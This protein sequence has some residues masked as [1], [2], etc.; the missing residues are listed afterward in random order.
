MSPQA[1]F[2]LLNEIV[3]RLKS[4]IPSSVSFVGCEDAEELIADATCIAAKIL[5]SVEARGRA[6]TPGN[7]AYFATKLTRQGRR[8]TGQRRHDPL[9]PMAQLSGRCRLVSL[10]APLAG[11][12]EGEENMC[13]HDALAAKTEDPAMTAARRLDWDRL[14]SFL[15]AL[16]REVLH[17]LMQDQDLTTLVPKLKRSRSSLQSDKTRLARLVREHLGEDVLARVQEQPGWRDSIEASRER[18]ACRHERQRVRD[19]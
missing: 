8:S 18:A 9:D 6:A 5:D 7:I 19:S 11:D 14:T 4:A 2:I 13:L 3:P 10:D 17:C 16:A 12:T 15:D 1:G